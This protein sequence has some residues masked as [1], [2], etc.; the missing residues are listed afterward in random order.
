VDKLASVGALYQPHNDYYVAIIN[1]VPEISK[2][3]THNQVEDD[4]T[5]IYEHLKLWLS[6]PELALKVGK[7]GEKMTVDQQSVLTRQLTMIEAI[8]EEFSAIK[9]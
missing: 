9:A 5:L 2:D 8:I 6:D 4:S 3:D 1:K 7:A